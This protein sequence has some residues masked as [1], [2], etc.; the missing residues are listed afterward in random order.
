ML[1]KS[2]KFV[3]NTTAVICGF[4]FLGNIKA[5][6][7]YKTSINSL[8]ITRYETECINGN[9]ADGLSYDNDGNEDR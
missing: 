6:N 4:T 3:A 8:K 7:L 5:N 9:N 2:Y 1:K